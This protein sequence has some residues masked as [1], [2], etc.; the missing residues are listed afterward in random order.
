MWRR[1]RSDWVERG[2]CDAEQ[3]SL[4]EKVLLEKNRDEGGQGVTWVSREKHPR[5]REEW[6]R[7]AKREE[8]WRAGEAPWKPKMNSAVAARIFNFLK[9]FLIK[10]NAT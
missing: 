8:P 7:D 1:A 4:S 6:C 3:S 9:F 5:Q 2:G 10:K